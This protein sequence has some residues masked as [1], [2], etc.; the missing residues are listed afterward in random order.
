MALKQLF[1]DLKYLVK[2]NS[3]GNTVE[4]TYV[5]TVTICGTRVEISYYNPKYKYIPGIKLKTPGKINIKKVGY[6][7]IYHP[8]CK[9]VNSAGKPMNKYKNYIFTDSMILKYGTDIIA[10]IEDDIYLPEVDTTMLLGLLVA[11]FYS[12]KTRIEFYYNDLLLDPG[13]IKAFSTTRTF[14][15]KILKKLNNKC[16]EEY[17]KLKIPVVDK[18]YND[19]ILRNPGSPVRGGILPKKLFAVG[20]TL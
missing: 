8:V 14:I 6:E 19:I 15:D 5:G 16:A 11:C 10:N 1:R 9:I 20:N 18:M 7:G 12:Y 3:F 4:S 17:I 2:V 13:H